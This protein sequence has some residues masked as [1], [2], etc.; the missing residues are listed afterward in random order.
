MAAKDSTPAAVQ[1][2]TVRPATFTA[3]AADPTKPV[4]I[5]PQKV[6]LSEFDEG[7]FRK[8]SE[9]EDSEPYHLK[10]VE[11]DLSGNTHHLK[12][13]DHFWTGTKEQFKAQFDKK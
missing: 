12:N 8:I 11:D 4:Q 3:S 6:D 5:G 1:H 7:Q 2:S 13:Q 9:P 10:I